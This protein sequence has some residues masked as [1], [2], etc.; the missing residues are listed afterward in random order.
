[1][2]IKSNCYSSVCWAKV[3]SEDRRTATDRWRGR[4]TALCNTDENDDV[5]RSNELCPSSDV[6]ERVRSVVHSTRTS[7]CKT[8]N[9]RDTVERAIPTEDKNEEEQ[10]CL[11][12]TSTTT[13]ANRSS[14]ESK[15]RISPISS[16]ISKAELSFPS[17]DLCRCS[18]TFEREVPMD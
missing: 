2:S 8:T 1:M 12:R 4:V 3:T 18:N 15:K 9:G 5:E 11:D 17:E 6:D 10:R 14:T 16:L 13:A 7:H